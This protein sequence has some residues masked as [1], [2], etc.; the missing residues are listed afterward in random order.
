MSVFSRLSRS[1]EDE[2]RERLAAEVHEAFQRW[3]AAQAY[4]DNVTDPELVECAIHNLDFT[5]K[6]YMY[7]V[8][9]LRGDEQPADTEAALSSIRTRR[10]A[11]D[12]LADDI[13]QAG[14]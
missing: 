2:A 9:K 1:K 8:K 14:A 6:H 5:R 7:L 12:P 4:F 3:Q 13:R 10:Y 11:S